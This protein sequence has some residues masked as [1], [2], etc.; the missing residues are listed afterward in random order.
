M[1]DKFLNSVMLRPIELENDIDTVVDI[2]FSASVRCHDFIPRTYWESCK[3]EMKD[4][5]LPQ[6]E[7]MIAIVDNKMVGFI[8]LVEDMIAAIFVSPDYQRKK[9][10][11]RLL[12]YA[13]ASHNNLSLQVYVKNVQARNFYLQNG[14][15]ESEMGLDEHTGEM[16]ITMNWHRSQPRGSLKDEVYG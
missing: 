10:G 13:F 8:S 6:A 5:Y 12:D 7:T 9:I 15:I 16:D 1:S 3:Q 11:S 4:V 2:W 14:F